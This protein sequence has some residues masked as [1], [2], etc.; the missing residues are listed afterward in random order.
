[1]GIGLPNGAPQ[2]VGFGTSILLIPRLV[3]GEIALGGGEEDGGVG[4]IAVFVFGQTL[5]CIILAILAGVEPFGAPARQ[6]IFILGICGCAAPH[7]DRKSLGN[8]HLLFGL[9][10]FG[11][12][13]TAAGLTEFQLHRGPR[14][15]QGQAHHLGIDSVQLA[16]DDLADH[17]AIETAIHLR[18]HG[19]ERQRGLCPA[20]HRFPRPAARFLHLPLKGQGR[21]AVGVHRKCGGVPHGH[22]RHRHRLPDDLQRRV[23]PLGGGGD[24]GGDNRLSAAAHGLDGIVIGPAGQQAVDLKGEVPV[25]SLAGEDLSHL[26][27]FVLLHEVLIDHIGVRR[28]CTFFPAQGHAGLVG[29]SQG[30]VLRQAGGTFDVVQHIAHHRHFL[31]S[32]R[33]G[34]CGQVPAEAVIAAG[35]R[36]QI[37]HGAAPGDGRG[38]EGGLALAKAA[39]HTGADAA[40]K[41]LH[42]GLQTH[43]I[44]VALRRAFAQLGL[45]LPGDHAVALGDRGEAKFTEHLVL[46]GH[47]L[48]AVVP[49]VAGGFARDGVELLFRDFGDAH[50]PGGLVI[51]IQREH[52]ILELTRDGDGHGLLFIAA[53]VV[54]N[55]GV[56]FIEGD[57]IGKDHHIVLLG[58]SLKADG[59]GGALFLGEL[60]LPLGGEGRLHIGRHYPQKIAPRLHAKAGADGGGAGCAA[61]LAHPLAEGGAAGSIIIALGQVGEVGGGLKD[62]QH[63]GILPGKGLALIL[64]IDGVVVHIRRSQDAEEVVVFTALIVDILV[65]AVK[66][67]AFTFAHNVDGIPIVVLALLLIGGGIDHLLPPFLVSVKIP[68]D[69]I[70]KP[71]VGDDTRADAVIGVVIAVPAMLRT[72]T[73]IAFDLIHLSG[74]EDIFRTAD[75]VDGHTG[76][77]GGLVDRVVVVKAVLYEIQDLQFA[78]AGSECLTLIPADMHAAQQTVVIDLFSGRRVMAQGD[79]IQPA[80]AVHIADVHRD[81]L[82]GIVLLVR[83]TDL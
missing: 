39:A 72:P 47:P 14:L 5:Q 13:R 68:G 49:I 7:R 43:G 31:V 62:G 67:A 4:G 2:G 8:S 50:G 45:D 57:G 52:V 77:G 54:G 40:A 61:A 73:A 21:V 46:Q 60:P 66:P 27:I 83:Q 41:G 12:R 15:A 78:V 25:L 38:V 34:P 9:L 58:A 10:D 6:R 55:I 35:A 71:C 79:H 42:A 30:E 51:L 18:G 44:G 64:Q 65:E 22:I 70:L 20:G 75:A 36:G 59:V 17:A 63:P 80:V 19:A 82:G 3:R 11:I 32:H 69:G 74:G 28:I 81:A 29:L 1:M 24:V 48:S 37:R 53:A 23:L 76:Q 16:V 33:G 56:I 26:H